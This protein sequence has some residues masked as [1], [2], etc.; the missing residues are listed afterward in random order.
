MSLKLHN[1]VMR[2]GPAS[3]PPVVDHLSLHLGQGE[4]GCLLGASGSGKTSVLRA[5][6]GFEAIESGEIHLKERLLSGPGQQVAAEKRRIGMVFQDYAL[7]PH[8]S[9]M[10][11]VV[12]G[13][14]TLPR[15]EQSSRCEELLNTVGLMEQRDRYP[16]ELSGG[17]QQRVALA[18]AL[19]LQ[20]DLLLMDE[21]FSNLDSALRERLSLEVRDL[22]KRQGI[23]ALFVTHS[24][25]EAFAIADR[26]GVVERGHLRQWA[27]PY[28]LYHHPC[29]QLTALATG[30][31]R[32]LNGT[33]LADGRIDSP[34]GPLGEAGPAEAQA[35]HPA[36]GHGVSLLLR[37]ED[38]VHD[39][40]SPT[41]A[42][43]ID[44][45][46]RGPV[47][48]YQLRLASGESIQILASSRC[49]HQVGEQIGIRPDIRHL[50]AFPQPSL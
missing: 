33:V 32:M 46:F 18:R 3:T 48:S 21:P 22:L 28:E 11:N 35:D 25:Q 44:R 38:I 14:H 27:S 30:E 23:T 5:I 19:V 42:E 4:I 1:I 37:P 47:T 34:F 15:Q 10:D 24:Q 29:D 39:D 2:Y 41:R 16:H 7:F 26:V 6:A 40:L 36:S 31:G 50:V 17:Q 12:F 45:A 20:P 9:V 13:L 43:V 49:D 8:L